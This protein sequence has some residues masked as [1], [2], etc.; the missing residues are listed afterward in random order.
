M[1]SFLYQ[2]SEAFFVYCGLY[3]FLF[4]FVY[5][6]HLFFVD[7]W[8]FFTV[9]GTTLLYAFYAWLLV[10]LFLFFDFIRGKISSTRTKSKL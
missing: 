5:L 1:N 3:V 9:A 10:M 8:T 2:A 4:Q 7:D 6:Y